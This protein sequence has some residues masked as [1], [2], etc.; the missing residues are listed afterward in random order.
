MIKVCL[1]GI[2]KA[3]KEIAKLIL[4]KKDIEIVATICSKNSLKKNKDLGTEI[5][6]KE[7]GIKIE[8]IDKLEEIILSSRPDV[9]VDFSIAESTMVSSEII[10]KSKVNL[11]IGT[12]GFKDDYLERLKYLAE[13]NKVGVIYAPNITF[14]VNVLMALTKISSVLLN[15]YDFQITESHHKN[16]KD[17]PSGTAN[18]IKKEIEE[19]FVYNGN[20]TS[21]KK[22][23]I[24]SVRAGGIIGKHEVM[25]VGDDD[26]ITISHESF[27]RK[28]FAAGAIKA[29]RFIAD[30]VGF[31]EM[32]EVM[33]LSKV[34][35]DLYS[36][37]DDGNNDIV[38]NA[39]AVDR[40]E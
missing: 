1:I 16:K 7:L 31:Y 30:K 3:G 34:I 35:A 29:V 38:S 2:G 39:I 28:V 37:T 21:E 12:T 22:I 6:I 24:N 15:N 33:N 9:V 23:P 40:L 4:D 36:N 17:I 26:R 5:G 10:L 27:S 13:Y 19:G 18:K 32:K 11:V 14:G 8:S 20:S 25:I